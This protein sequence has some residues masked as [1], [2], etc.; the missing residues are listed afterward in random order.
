ML[1]CWAGGT[2]NESVTAWE[3]A[4]GPGLS[5]SLCMVGP[6]ISLLA[7]PSCHSCSPRLYTPPAPWSP[8]IIFWSTCKEI[9]VK[10]FRQQCFSLKKTNKQINKK[11]KKK[12]QGAVPST[13]A[14]YQHV[15]SSKDPTV[16]RHRRR[17]ATARAT[18]LLGDLQQLR[19]T[20][21]SSRHREPGQLTPE[22]ARWRE[23]SIRP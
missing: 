1:P 11:K 6:V 4:W 10:D 12:N 5:P 23:A 8:A 15:Y 9:C 20:G 16:W 3:L 13:W 14:D 19:D 7:Y 2:E 17:S 21:G 18:G 22:I